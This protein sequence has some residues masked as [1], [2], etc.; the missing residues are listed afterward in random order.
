MQR[1]MDIMTRDVATAEA[2]TPLVELYSGMIDR[3]IRH[4][5]VVENGRLIG[6]LSD[7]DVLPHIRRAKAGVV[8]VERLCARDVMTPCPITADPKAPVVD[9][10]NLMIDYRFDSVP[11][12]E[13]NGKLVGLVTSTDLLLLLLPPYAHDAVA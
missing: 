12:V 8:T 2:D 9:L 5:P 6:I 4:V 10:V 3:S 13:S 1:A 7:R 11:V